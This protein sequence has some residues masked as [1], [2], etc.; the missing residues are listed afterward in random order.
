MTP[1]YTL[2]PEWPAVTFT[3]ETMEDVIAKLK[4]YLL[5]RIHSREKLK[6]DLQDKSMLINLVMLEVGRTILIDFHHTSF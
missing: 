1:I 3:T 5:K 2:A 6:A 4:A